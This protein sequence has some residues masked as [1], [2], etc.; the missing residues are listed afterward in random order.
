MQAPVVIDRKVALIIARESQPGLSDSQVIE[1]QQI[2]LEIYE[3][4]HCASNA[5]NSVASSSGVTPSSDINTTLSIL[6]FLHLI[7][8]FLLFPNRNHHTRMN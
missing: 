3:K 2:Q 4:T 1:S 6:Q 5:L 8:R 7:L